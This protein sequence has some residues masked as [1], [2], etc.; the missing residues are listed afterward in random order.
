MLHAQ[1]ISKKQASAI[2]LKHYFTG[3]ECP[4]G[5]IDLRRV[6][7]YCCIACGTEWITRERKDNP[8]FLERQRKLCRENNLKRYYEDADYREKINREAAARWKVMH[9]TEKGREQAKRWTK[10]WRDKNR[11]KVNATHRAY[12]AKHAEK[13]AFIESFRSCVK[14]LKNVKNG[15]YKV[16]CLGYSRNEFFAHMEALFKPGMS[17]EN[18][19]QWHIDHVKPVIAFIR[20]ENFDLKQVHALSNLQPLWASENMRKG[21]KESPL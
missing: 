18:H 1:L 21:A 3:K 12:R 19:G 20:E 14:R 17:W 9:H 8:E 5:H 13:F 6:S 4:N 7:S 10:K 16:K 2:G 11:D 15:D